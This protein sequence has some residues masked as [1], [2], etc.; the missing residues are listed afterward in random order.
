MTSGSSSYSL[1]LDDI[2][3]FSSDDD[4]ISSTDKK[5]THQV[6]NSPSSITPSRK[7]HR[8]H[9]WKHFLKH[10][11]DNSDEEEDVEMKEEEMETQE[12]IKED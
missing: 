2:Q 6:K 9:G 7:S 3:S 11:K 4:V 1:D 12:E 5:A 10:V 8:D